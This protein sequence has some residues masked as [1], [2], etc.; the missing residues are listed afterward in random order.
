MRREVAKARLQVRIDH[1]DAV[2]LVAAVGR[3]DIG[4]IKHDLRVRL[5]VPHAE[6]VRGDIH[7]LFPDQLPVVAVQRHPEAGLLI[8]QVL[9]LEADQRRVEGVGRQ[10]AYP[11]LARE[12]VVLLGVL[13]HPD[14]A[15]KALAGQRGRLGVGVVHEEV[16]ATIGLDARLVGALARPVLL[17]VPL[18]P[19]E[20]VGAGP[21]AD[22]AGAIL[23]E[24]PDACRAH[25]EVVHHLNAG[26]GDRKRHAA[27][28]GVLQRPAVGGNLGFRRVGFGALRVRR[29]DCASPVR[30]I[31]IHPVALHRLQRCDLTIG[32]VGG[33]L[34]D[35]GGVDREQRLLV[36][37]LPVILAHL[38]PL[39]AGQR[40]ITALPRR[41]G[42]VRVAR[43]LGPEG[44][45]IFPQVVGL[46]RRDG[47]RGA[48]RNQHGG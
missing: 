28:P 25:L 15:D 26:L 33:V 24:R 45:Q 2:Q 43:L 13:V 30:R 27:G 36:L 23:I 11:A 4:F 39:P 14:R 20:V 35:A 3:V 42:A 7:L 17:Q 5:V 47:R 21:R 19:G 48:R 46:L 38:A 32:Q 31:D 10:P 8:D 40:C 6:H 41:D 18:V 12:V 22:N 16:N 29:R 1:P 34:V 37:E 9:V 44:R